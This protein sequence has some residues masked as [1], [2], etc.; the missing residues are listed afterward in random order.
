MLNTCK[1][2]LFFVEL[3]SK[4]FCSRIYIF[5]YYVECTYL[6]TLDSGINVGVG[7]SIFEKIKKKE[8]INSNALKFWFENF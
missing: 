5:T 3:G 1:V 2:Y 4:P 6:S 8:K 7:L